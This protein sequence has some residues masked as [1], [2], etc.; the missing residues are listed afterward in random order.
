MSVGTPKERP[1]ATFFATIIVAY[2]RPIQELGSYRHALRPTMGLQPPYALIFRIA[3][4]RSVE[5][6]ICPLAKSTIK[7]YN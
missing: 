3:E 1:L 5:R 6:G 7:S 2:C 4:I